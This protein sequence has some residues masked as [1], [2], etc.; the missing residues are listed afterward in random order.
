MSLQEVQNYVPEHGLTQLLSLD[1][2]MFFGHV[3]VSSQ[4]QR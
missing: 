2:L 1:L 4:A 3:Y